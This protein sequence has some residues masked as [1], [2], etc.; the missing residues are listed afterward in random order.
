MFE[1]VSDKKSTP[2]GWRDLNFPPA[3]FD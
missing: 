3:R 2:P 1:S